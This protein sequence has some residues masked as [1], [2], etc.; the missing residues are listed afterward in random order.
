MT[1]LLPTNK[2]FIFAKIHFQAQFYE[3]NPFYFSIISLGMEVVDTC[4]YKVY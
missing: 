2:T 1:A 4:I 3:I